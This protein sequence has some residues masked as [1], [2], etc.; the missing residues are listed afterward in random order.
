LYG[1]VGGSISMRISG[2]RIYEETGKKWHGGKILYIYQA[3]Y[4]LKWIKSSAPDSFP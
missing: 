1:D 4:I 2:R 3:D